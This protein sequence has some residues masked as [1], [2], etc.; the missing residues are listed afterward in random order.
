MTIW[1]CWKC[2]ARRRST[3]SLRERDRPNRTTD[4]LLSNLVAQLRAMTGP[5]LGLAHSLI[6]YG[7]IPTK[8]GWFFVHLREVDTKVCPVLAY[9]AFGVQTCD[10]RGHHSVIHIP[11]RGK[12]HMNIQFEEANYGSFSS[13]SLSMTV[14]DLGGAVSNSMCSMV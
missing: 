4:S 13:Q 1:I 11:Q 9:P 7:Q 3:R 2:D 6:P 8:H 12:Q 14:Q 10:E 5:C